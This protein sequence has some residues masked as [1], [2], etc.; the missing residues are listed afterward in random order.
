M[1]HYIH[2]QLLIIFL[3]CTISCSGTQYSGTIFWTGCCCCFF[4]LQ[5]NFSV[6]GFLTVC[7]NYIHDIVSVIDNVGSKSNVLFCFF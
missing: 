3:K 7:A 4:F 2:Y 6:D 1:I 5:N